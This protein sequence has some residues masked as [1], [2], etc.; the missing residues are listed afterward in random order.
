MDQLAEWYWLRPE[1]AA[2]SLSDTERGWVYEVDGVIVG[3]A[4]GDAT[5]S[6]LTV[7]ACL[8]EFEGRGIGRSLI[9]AVTGWLLESGS[10]TPW[11]MTANNPGFRAYGFYLSQGWRP[12][13]EIDGDEV[14]FVYAPAQP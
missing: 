1:N 11:L 12:T 13:S 6:E 14:K 5:R 3:F 9:D 7:I 10:A 2:D 4:K 8:P